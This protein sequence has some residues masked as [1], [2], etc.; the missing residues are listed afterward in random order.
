[1]SIWKTLLPVPQARQMGEIES[2]EVLARDFDIEMP[3][4]DTKQASLEL[5]PIEKDAWS[6]QLERAG[7]V[8][9]GQSD[10]SLARANA[11]E[12]LSGQEVRPV[13]V[14]SMDEQIRMAMKNASR[15]AWATVRRDV[16][17]CHLQE[18]HA[19]LHEVYDPVKDRMPRL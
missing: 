7:F 4:D 3:D 19:G 2:A 5:A 6:Q 9:P 13:H 10:R 15:E 12:Q 14:V 1:M 18:I 16:D 17:R 8:A 11:S